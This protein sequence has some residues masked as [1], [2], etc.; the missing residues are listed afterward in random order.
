MIAYGLYGSDERY[1][2]GAVENARLV[3]ELMPGW[4][5]RFYVD[6]SVPPE[7]VE[8]IE[9]EGGEVSSDLGGLE[10]R[11]AGMFWRFT[12][13]ADPCV[14]AWLI[15]DVDCRP[16][17][18]EAAAVAEWLDSDPDTYPFHLIRDHPS[19][20]NFPVSGGLWGGRVPIPDMVKL[21]ASVSHDNYLVDMLFLRDIIWPRIRDYTFQHDAFSCAAYG[22]KGLPTPRK[23]GEHIGAVIQDGDFRVDDV[24]ILLNNLPEPKE[25]LS[26]TL[27][28]TREYDPS[29]GMYYPVLVFVDP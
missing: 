2:D 16:T 4:K 20:S 11:E 18:R 19:H 17:E 1:T 3:K 6:D 9:R 5:A 13:A 14:A 27:Y 10:G 22:G 29:I 23:G 28:P 7:V 26:Q 15:R 8:A 25:C 12:V 24:L 21:A